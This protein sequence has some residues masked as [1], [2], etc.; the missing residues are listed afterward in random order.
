MMNRYEKIVDSNG[1][2]IVDQRKSGFMMMGTYLKSNKWTGL[3]YYD[4]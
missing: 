1:N 2:E 3:V 4:I